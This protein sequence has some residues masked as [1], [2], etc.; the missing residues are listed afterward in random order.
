MG[1]NFC[2]IWEDK[3]RLVF[4]QFPY[5]FTADAEKL[6]AQPSK[7]RQIDT[8]LK[9][10]MEPLRCALFEYLF[11]S[12]LGVTKPD[13]KDGVPMPAPSMD[14]FEDAE[15]KAFTNGVPLSPPR[16]EQ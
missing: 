13:A 2:I 1:N 9:R 5:T 12:S 16:V 15:S 6:A 10:S 14:I 11:H 4:I 7:Y 8:T 3:E